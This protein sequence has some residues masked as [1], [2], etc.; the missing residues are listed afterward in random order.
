MKPITSS[1]IKENCSPISSN[2]VIWQGPDIS[3]INV[4][5]GDS[6]SE[7]VYKLATEIC[8]FQGVIGI[9]D[10]DF[11]CLV[12]VCNNEPAIPGTV[13]LSLAL[14]L[15]VD[16]I[17]CLNDIVINL[18][19]PGTEYVE[20]TLNLPL[21]LQYVDPLTGLPVTS[22]ILHEFVVV[23]AT[24]VCAINTLV[25]LHTVQISNLTTQVNN[26]INTPP[27]ALPTVT[28]SCILPSVATQMNVVLTEL[29]LRFCGLVTVLGTNTQ[30]TTAGS[31]QCALL[32][33]APSFSGGGT[34]SSL[35][36]WNPTITT[37]AQSMQNL[38]ITVCDIRSVVNT[39]LD[40]CS[41]ADCTKFTLG[42]TVGIDSLRENVTLFFSPGTSLP[43]GYVD[44][45]VL[46]ATVSIT[47]GVGN[48]FVGVAV[49]QIEQ[50]NISGISFDVSTA[51]LNPSQTY[52]VT[53]QGCIKSGT[54]TCEKTVIETSVP[55]CPVVM[56]VVATLV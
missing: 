5:S 25:N 3:C 2:C 21:C 49:L 15:L 27:A 32:G 12:E 30:I 28:P 1:S 37:F 4:C 35:P 43:V 26:I 46:G 51:G 48:T 44:C 6:V 42:Y 34:M 47:D 9:S 11:T 36:G 7:I 8:A 33:S 29:E 19:T 50:S 41:Q 45:N 39:L 23:L 54:K 18:P 13:T 20:P 56:G 24:K 40:C 22:L 31:A 14:Q 17:C 10:V 52:T 16:K 55:P 53:V 38:W